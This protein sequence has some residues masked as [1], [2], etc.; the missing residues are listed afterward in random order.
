MSRKD[1]ILIAQALRSSK[2][3]EYTEPFAA[4]SAR[5]Q[6]RRDITALISALTHTNIL[7]DKDKFRKACGD[8]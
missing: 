8:E 1:F 4:T 5:A 7:F 3:S 2:P 6:W